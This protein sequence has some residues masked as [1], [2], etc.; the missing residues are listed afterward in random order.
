MK[1]GERQ[2]GV[3]L[4][5]VDRREHPD[6]TVTYLE[7]RFADFALLVPGLDPVQPLHPDLRHLI[8]DGTV[9]FSRKSV[10]AGAPK[11]VSADIAGGREQFV[12]VALAVSDMHDALRLCEQAVDCLRF[13]SQR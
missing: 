4:L 10:D 6:A 5:L 8:G 9:S 7:N 3:S 1:D 13:S 2:F 11:E 12:D